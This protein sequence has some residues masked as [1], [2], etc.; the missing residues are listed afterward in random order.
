[1]NKLNPLS[2]RRLLVGTGTAVAL[3]M[4]RSVVAAQKQVSS[5]LLSALPAPAPI[6]GGIQIPDGPF[7]HWF[8]PGL[9]MV[10]TPFLG[11]QG[12]GLDIEPCT[13]TNFDGFTAYAVS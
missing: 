9:E 6:P 1:M 3:G 7:I 5:Q 11:L 10:T 4:T 13:L 8:V 12:M 2:R